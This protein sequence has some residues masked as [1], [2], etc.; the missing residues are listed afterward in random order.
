MTENTELFEKTDN[1]EPTNLETKYADW[2]EDALRRKALAAD[3]HIRTLEEENRNYRESMKTDEKLE[4]VLSKL[5]Q[6]YN[7]QQFNYQPNNEAHQPS[8][9]NSAQESVTREDVLK[10]VE[11][12]YQN[13]VKE[14]T[15]KSNVEYVANELRKAWGDN[16]S[17]TLSEK[18]KDLGVDQSFLESMAET[19]PK[20]FLRLV[21][22]SKETGT[23][24]THVPPKSSTST[25]MGDTTYGE[26]YKDFKEQEKQNPTLKHNAAFQRRKMEAA[27]RLGDSF[28]N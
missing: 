27:A 7:Q 23:P 18:V 24:N 28:Y 6:S 17:K 9:R 22:P 4:A 19:H 10:L 1:N 26:T 3:N 2:D 13:K 5:D 12:T 8:E 15:A 25:N 21:S 20:A 16:Y 14:S 11:Q